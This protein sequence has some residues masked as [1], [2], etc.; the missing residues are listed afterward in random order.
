M[1]AETGLTGQDGEAGTLPRSVCIDG[2]DDFIG[3]LDGAKDI[4]SRVRDYAT[5]L[6][7]Q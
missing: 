7:F 4:K 3:D 1:E 5:V 6:G 2:V